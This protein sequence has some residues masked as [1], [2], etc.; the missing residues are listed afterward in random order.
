MPDTSATSGRTIPV[1]EVRMVH[2][3]RR[4]R[5]NTSTARLRAEDSQEMLH[6]AAGNVRFIIFSRQRSAST[7]FVGLLNLHPN[8]TCR[9]ESFSN[10]FTAEKMRAYLGFS[11]RSEQHEHIPEFMSRFWNACPTRAC[12]FKILHAQVR[13]P[14]G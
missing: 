3:W 13:H 14:C 6:R 8:I 12:G 9:W 10:S 1:P 7:T 2:P 11:N 4:M 5:Y